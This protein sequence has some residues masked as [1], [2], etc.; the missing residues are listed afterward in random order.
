MIALLKSLIFLLLT[1]IVSLAGTGWAVPLPLQGKAP[2]RPAPLLGLVG[3]VPMHNLLSR[4]AVQV[5]LAAGHTQKEVAELTQIPVRSQR[6]IGKEERVSDVDDAAE[7]R[8][9]RVGRPSK[10]TTYRDFV[11][12]LLKQEPTLMTLE[13]LR[14]C[15]ARGYTGGKSAMYE[16]VAELRPH[17]SDLQMR[18]EGVPG[19]FS[20]HDF[21]QVDVRFMD[22][23]TKR[24][25]F[26]ASRLKWSRWVEVSIVDNE[27][28][29]TL[30]RTLLDHFVR[31]GGVPLCAVFDR[32]KTVAIKWRK[33]GTITEWNSVFAYAALEV[34]F[35]AEVCWPRSPR[36]KGSVENLVG[37][38]KGSF[39][40]QRRFY[41]MDDLQQQLAEW[42]QEVNEQR[43]NRATDVS[44]LSRI[45]EERQRL[46][47]PKVEA[48]ELALRVPVSV[49]PTGYAVHATNS[50]SMPPKSAGLPG[51]LYL[52]RDR[53][54]IIAGRH[55]ATHER[56]FGRNQ[57]STLAEH[58]AGQLAELS[59]DRGKRYLRRQHLFETGESAV[60]FITELVHR[61]PRRWSCGVDVLHDLLQQH[62][63]DSM[64]RA[65]RAAVDVGV[66]DVGYVERCL[67]GSSEPTQ[68]WL[69]NAG[70]EA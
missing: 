18:F 61:H 31:F 69:W 24:V 54:R 46:R 3:E 49:G 5:L 67:T 25:R 33:D 63:S 45:D 40:K 56:L 29:E 37:W 16:I 42:H 65:F 59:G 21:G 38:V 55:Q 1:L 34:G 64:N 7:R 6:R 30:V 53:V 10:T 41:D 48:D 17:D 58:R 68:L 4:H 13:V 28:T 20:Q 2:R 44:P 50:Y 39:F 27:Q 57:T 19:E 62:G 9:R 35:T 22:G 8:R 66:F 52:Y 47:P 26:F 70:G 15:R 43:P 14:R 32:P 23:R 51:T 12:E 36:Q 11:S 60:H